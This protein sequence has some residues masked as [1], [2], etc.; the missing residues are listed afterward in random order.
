M[1][2]KS[3]FD[4]G[5]H[6]DERFHFLRLGE[7]SK[8]AEGLIYE[9]PSRSAKQP[10]P[11]PRRGVRPETGTPPQCM[12]QDVVMHQVGLSVHIELLTATLQQQAG[13]TKRIPELTAEAL[14][15]V[16]PE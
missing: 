2:R 13:V 4:A 15:K 16:L 7:K 11:S 9:F 14:I 10:D 1:I 5:T 12:K 3:E 6:A 8:I